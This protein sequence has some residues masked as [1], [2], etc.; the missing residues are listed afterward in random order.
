MGNLRGGHEIYTF[1][2]VRESRTAEQVR[3]GYTI[4]VFVVEVALTEIGEKV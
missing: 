3:C 1:R 4:E 2:S